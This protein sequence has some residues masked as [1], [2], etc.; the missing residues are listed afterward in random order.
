MIYI[1]KKFA[2]VAHPA[3]NLL[4]ANV[5]TF[6]DRM[7]V[8][9]PTKANILAITKTCNLPIMS[10]KIPR[11]KLPITEPMKNTDCPSVGFQALLHTQFN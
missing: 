8:M 5:I 4:I 1:I 10:A 9:F 7:V 2:S 11:V 3:K 6:V